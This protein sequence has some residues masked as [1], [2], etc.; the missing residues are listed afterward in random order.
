MI[1]IKISQAQII[2]KDTSKSKKSVLERSAQILSD[3]SGI[4]TKIIFNKLYE[5]EK[6]GSTS[7][8]NGVAIP[9]A[10]IDGIKYPFLAV[11]VLEE[12]V[13]FVNF[14]DFDVDIIFC[15]IVPNDGHNNHLELLAA[16]SEKLDKNEIRQ[17]IRKTKD[18]SDIIKYIKSNQ[19]NYI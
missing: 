10:R 8:G 3:A 4:D 13:D 19:L 7:V 1:S 16:L 9:H 2:L 11:I 12:S 5:R 14:D 15:L 17:Q 18:E 6:L